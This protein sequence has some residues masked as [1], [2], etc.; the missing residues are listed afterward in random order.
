MKS[1]S[2]ALA[3]LTVLA[4]AVRFAPTVNVRTQDTNRDGR[5]DIWRTYARSGQLIRVAVDT[6]FD[7]LPDRIETYDAK[8]LI[9]RESDRN[10]DKRIDTIEEFDSTAYHE[11][12]TV[13][14][15]DFDGNAD[16]LVLFRAGKPV[17][18]KWSD[19]A[20][21]RGAYDIDRSGQLRPLW[22][23][24]RADAAIGVHTPVFPGGAAIAFSSTAGA[25]R[26]RVAAVGPNFLVSRLTAAGVPAVWSGLEFSHHLR[27]PPA[28]SVL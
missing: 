2:A 9:S 19:A 8:G 27:G 22:D 24:F 18:T 15:V 16:L 25:P 23:P 10:F 13:V 11:T 1:L 5:P 3:G 28:S 7:N 14:D 6:N 26:D 21:S 20:T 17:D 4:G 12:R